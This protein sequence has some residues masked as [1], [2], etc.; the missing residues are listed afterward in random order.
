MSGNLGIGV[1]ATGFGIVVTGNRIGTVADGTS[2]LGNTGSGF[3]FFVGRHDWWR[4]AGFGQSHFRETERRP[5]TSGIA[6]ASANG[7]IQGNFV[8]TD[9]TG[10]IALP[11]LGAGISIGG[12]N[13]LVGGSA[14]GAGNL[15]SGNTGTGVAL[16]PGSSHLRPSA[17]A[18]QH[19][20]GKFHRRRCYRDGRV[21]EQWRWD[22]R[23]RWSIWRVG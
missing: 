22:F 8:G 16:H 15:V 4:H 6:L 19:R 17:R 13:N 11:N 5:R 14:P 2:A 9:I 10:K 12:N 7:T 21:T 1:Y 3:A 23:R 20:S 18:R